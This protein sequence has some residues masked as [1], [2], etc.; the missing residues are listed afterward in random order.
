MPYTG[1]HVALSI[2]AKAWREIVQPP[3]FGKRSGQI[4]SVPREDHVLTRARPL[5]VS[6]R[7]VDVPDDIPRISDSNWNLRPNSRTAP[8]PRLKPG[9]ARDIQTEHWHAQIDLCIKTAG[10]KHIPWHTFTSSC[11]YDV[12][13]LSARQSRRFIY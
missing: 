5:S 2:I 3:A 4:P 1:Y 9:V 8:P 11:V 13:A 12:E 6:W 7:S 10:Q